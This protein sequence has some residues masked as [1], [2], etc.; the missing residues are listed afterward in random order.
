[1]LDRAPSNADFRMMS[2]A[3]SQW[4]EYYEVKPDERASNLL[5]AKALDLFNEGYNSID[6]I[7]TML[8]GTY[9]GLWATRVN[10]ATSAACH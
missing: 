9:V 6:D 4:F 10:A 7:S 8:I 5:C 3:V 1:M 2:L